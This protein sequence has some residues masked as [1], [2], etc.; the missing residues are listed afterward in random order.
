MR[1]RSINMIEHKKLEIES[2]SKDLRIIENKRETKNFVEEM[3]STTEMIGIMP[4]LYHKYPG[5]FYSMIIDRFLI[6]MLLG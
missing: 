6:S 1:R 3:I 2:R 4:S 5:C